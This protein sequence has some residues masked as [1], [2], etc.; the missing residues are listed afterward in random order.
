MMRRLFFFA[1]VAVASAL[2]A[3]T[4]DD[5]FSTSRSDV[6][7]F[8]ADTVSLDTVFSTV[9][10]STY[11]FWVY[12]NSGDGLRLSTVRLQRGNQSG[13]RVNVDGT[14]LDT[15]NGSLASGFEVRKGDSLRVFVEL[16]SPANG[17]DE[18]QLVEDN[19]VFTLESGVEQKVNLRAFSWDAELV[20]DVVVSGDTTIA[21][22]KPIVVYG[23]ITVD[24]SAT[25][26]IA[27]PTKLYFHDGAGL[28]VYGRLVVSG[29]GG[30]GGD[31]VMRGD[32]TD[33]MFDYLPYDRVSGQ[34]KGVRIHPSSTGN[35]ISHAD[36]HSAEDGIVCDSAAYDSTTERLTL[37]Y[38]T[39]H[40][41]KGVGLSSHNANISLANCQVSNTLGDCLA[42]Y[43]GRASVVYCTLAQ[44]YPFSGDRGVALRFANVREGNPVELHLMECRNSL[45][46][47]Y[48]EDEVMG[49]VADTTVACN[50]LFSNCILRT[51]VVTDS[52]LLAD[53]DNVLMETPNDSV[54]GKA[55]F[56]GIDEDN[57]RY[58]FRLDSVSTARGRALPLPAYADD[59]YG[60]PRGDKPDAGCYQY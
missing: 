56:V 48:A 53:F 40:N 6:L 37:R 51:P 9:P 23:G 15:S 29:D 2:V 58:D 17:A 12:N 52:T 45:V 47:G 26:T 24:S 49:E 41:C 3:C 39:I 59:R 7:S 20:G 27:A 36:I 33:R 43:G 55:H 19:L 38:V 21:S 16:T 50:Y 13:Y 18:P 46:T 31:V 1:I 10:T 34:W 60:K 4:D 54:E 28:D 57:L 25:L 30:E 35:Y 14:F 22:T 8:S 42:V 11:T 44:F 32:R 5:S